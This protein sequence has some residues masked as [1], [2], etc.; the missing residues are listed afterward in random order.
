[1]TKEKKRANF[2][3][4]VSTYQSVQ[5]V[6][7]KNTQARLVE[8]FENDIKNTYIPLEIT[9]TQNLP[10]TFWKMATPSENRCSENVSF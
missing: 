5:F 3:E 8:T 1:M 2:A 4:V 7:E 6:R 9:T 10:D